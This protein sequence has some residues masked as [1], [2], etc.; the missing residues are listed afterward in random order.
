MEKYVK[1][2]R[3]AAMVAGETL[4]QMQGTAAVKIKEDRSRVTEADIA[5]DTIIRE[6]LKKQFPDIPY[7]SE[8]YKPDVNYSSGLW[9]MVDPLDGTDNYVMGNPHFC[10]SIAL[11][12]GEVP[13][14]GVVRDPRLGETFYASR[15][16]GAFCDDTR[17]SC[18]LRT[19]LKECTVII[20]FGRGRRQ[21]EWVKTLIFEHL[22]Y[23]LDRM[24]YFGAAALDIS[25][26]ACG[27][28]DAAIYSL[29][30][31]HDFAAAAVILNEA[32]GTLTDFSG[33]FQAKR[34]EVI[35]G[36]DHIHGELLKVI[37]E[38]TEKK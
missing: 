5:S 30:N 22:I 33:K 31:L 29:L 12:D 34:S 26:V 37:H 10:V 13:V 23:K 15:G 19:I 24:R 17:I 35:A 16:N 3:E 20:E 21:V 32:G 38:Y 7:K 11:I 1:A 18:S 14:A 6:M 25:Y 2:M 8:E 28:F 9:W 36:S 4:L 27:R